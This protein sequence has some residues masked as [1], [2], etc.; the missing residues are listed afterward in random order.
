MLLLAS[1]HKNQVATHVCRFLFNWYLETIQHHNKVPTDL[2]FVYSMNLPY[3]VSAV[4]DWVSLS[5]C[6]SSA[7]QWIC[8]CRNLAADWNTPQLPSSA[9]MSWRGSG[10][11]LVICCLHCVV[12]IGAWEVKT[13]EHVMQQAGHGAH[14]EREF[15]KDIV[16]KVSGVFKGV[17]W[18]ALML[19]FQSVTA[20][21]QNC[22]C[23][24]AL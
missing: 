13:R 14:R 24:F 2:T 21:K 18:F 22:C 11:R 15:M 20:Y 23:C 3:S 4:Q 16:E 6:L 1:S 7:R 8:L 12:T 5:V 10:T 17:K 19:W 9:T